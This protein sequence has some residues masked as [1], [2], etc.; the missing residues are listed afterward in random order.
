MYLQ[1]DWSRT[2]QYWPYCTL[3]LITLVFDKEATT[4]EF[5]GAKK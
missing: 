5:R 1:S 2:V 4:F 3:D